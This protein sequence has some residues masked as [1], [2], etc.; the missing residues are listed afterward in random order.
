[1]TFLSR[2][3]DTQRD[4]RFCFGFLT[5][6]I[7]ITFIKAIRPPANAGS[8]EYEFEILGPLVAVKEQAQKCLGAYKLC[9]A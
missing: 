2:V 8:S 7:D 5:N 6:M 9:S 3:L 1:M 4:R